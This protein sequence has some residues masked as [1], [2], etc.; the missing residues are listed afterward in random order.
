M[1]TTFQTIIFPVPANCI[2]PIFFSFFNLDQID[3]KLCSFL[4]LRFSSAHQNA[5]PREFGGKWGTEVSEW[6]RI[7]LT[8]GSQVPCERKKIVKLKKK[9]GHILNTQTQ[10]NYNNN[11]LQNYNRIKLTFSIKK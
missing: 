11:K 3:C 7:I 2:S 5:M 1:Q 4:R 10:T 6:G 9:P 8:L